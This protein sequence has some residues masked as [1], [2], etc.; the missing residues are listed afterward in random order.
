M[1]VALRAIETTGIVDAYH[2]LLL[3]ETLP[4]N[5]PKKV[6]MSAGCLRKPSF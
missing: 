4:I 5:G 3:D 1:D 6:R 2:H